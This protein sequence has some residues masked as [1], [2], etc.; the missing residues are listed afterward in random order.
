MGNIDD[1]LKSNEK[2][3]QSTLLKCLE[4]KMQLGWKDYN[5]SKDHD[6]IPHIAGAVHKKHIKKVYFTGD[7]CTCKSNLL[8]GTRIKK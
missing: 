3:L 8:L 1:D 4:H 2:L 5:Y 7:H 6:I